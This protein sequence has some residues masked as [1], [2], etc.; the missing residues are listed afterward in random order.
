MAEY[1]RERVSAAER[2]MASVQAQLEEVRRKREKQALAAE[3]AAA[4][5][6]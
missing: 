1:D 5:R 6:R 4:V 2:D 3:T